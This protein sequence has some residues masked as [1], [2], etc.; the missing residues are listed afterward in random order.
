MKKDSSKTPIHYSTKFIVTGRSESYRIFVWGALCVLF[1]AIL[2]IFKPNLLQPLDFINYDLLLRNFPD[3]HASK[4]LIIVDLDEKSLNRYGQWPWPR[5]RIAELLDKIAAMKPAVISLDIFFTEPDRTSAGR[6]LKDLGNTYNLNINLDGLPAEL[7]DND[8]ILTQTLSRGPFILGNK[9]QFNKIETSPEQ[10]F[11]HPVNISFTNDVKTQGKITGLP[12]SKAVLCNLKML[13]EK[14]STSGFV[15]FSPDQ[16]GMLRRLPMLIQNNGKVYVSLGFATVLKLK[17]TN[18]LVLQRDGDSLQSIHYME[19][20]VPVDKHGQILIKFRGA[21]KSYDYVS[22]M[23]IMNGTIPAERLKGRIAFVGTSAAGLN[24]LLTTPFDPIFPGVEVHA[25][26][27]DN[28]LRGDFIAV[29][30]WSNGLILLLVIGLCVILCLFIAYRSAASGFIVMLIFLAGLWFLTQQLFFRAGMFV[31][32]TFPMVAVICSYIFITV[33]KYR[34][35]EKKMLSN[36]QEL[37]VTQD[38]TI[39]SMAN[40]AEYRDKETGGHIKRTRTYVKLLAEH[41]RHHD[42]YKH[43]LSDENIDI[44]YKSAP[45]H[46]IGK[47]AIPDKILL[48]PARLTEDEVEIM[49]THTTIGHDVIESSVRKLGKN[50]FLTIAAEI[51]LS[52]QEKWDGSGFPQGLKGNEIPISGRLMALADVYDALTSKRVYKPPLSH[53]VAVDIIKKGRGMHFD[54]DIVDAFLEIQEKFRNV[55]REFADFEEEREALD[56]DIPLEDLTHDSQ[57]FSARE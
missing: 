35:E 28:L 19:T 7:S 44:L 12:E 48:K 23:D 9:F 34:L 20:S 10:C 3:N 21:N 13:S 15:N 49:K 25:T 55:A 50:S 38:V 30:N 47:V 57:K 27:V 1:I 26:V 51:A 54:P 11:L 33:I 46:D 29:P 39:E 56:K 24:D 31:G 37:L 4:K 40:L 32:T 45:L 41:L 16:D 6:L 36:M 17:E 22:A 42:K 5:Y 14:V 53:A 43:F 52:H 8:K 18:N 2:F